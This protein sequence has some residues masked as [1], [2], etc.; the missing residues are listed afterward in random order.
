VAGAIAPSVDFMIFIR[1]DEMIPYR[2]IE[3][4]AFDVIGRKG[5]IGGQDNEQFGRIWAQCRAEGLFETFEKLG[6]WQPGSQTGGV[7]LGISRVE[8]DPAKREFFYMIAIETLPGVQVEGLE[9]YMVPAC[10]W[11]AFECRG[12]VPQAI[13]KSEMFAFMEWLPASGYVHALAPEMEVYFTGADGSSDDCYSEFWL[14]VT[15]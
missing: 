3:R 6:H 4:P 7:N 9:T 5:W 12:K 14:P 1:R 2:L 10:T 11:A 15:R 13:V 8:A